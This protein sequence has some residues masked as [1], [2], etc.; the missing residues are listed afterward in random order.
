MSM[1]NKMQTAQNAC[2][3][4]CLVMEGKNHIGLNHFKKINWLPVKNRVE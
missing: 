2:I 3:R 4:F 1:E